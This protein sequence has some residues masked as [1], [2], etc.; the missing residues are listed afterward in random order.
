MVLSTIFNSLPKLYFSDYIPYHRSCKTIDSKRRK[1]CF[2]CSKRPSSSNRVRN[3]G[4]FS[5]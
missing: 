4:R 2:S 3:G 5:S 1:E